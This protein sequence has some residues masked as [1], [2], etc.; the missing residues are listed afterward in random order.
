MNPATD[1]QKQVCCQKS[2]EMMKRTGALDCLHDST[3]YYAPCF[4]LFK[5]SVYHELIS[6][7]INIYTYIYIYKYA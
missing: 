3:I 1:G 7:N 4:A 2:V 6:V 5:Q